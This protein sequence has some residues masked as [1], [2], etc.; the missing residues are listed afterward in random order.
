MKMG[1]RI[2]IDSATL[3]NKGLEIIEAHWL[4]GFSPAQIDVLIHPES[5]IH[6][7]VEFN[8][9]AIIAQLAVPDMRLPIQYVLTYPNRVTMNG[10][11]LALD[12]ASLRRLTFC[13]PDL[14]R[15]P[16]LELARKA[17]QKGGTAPC[18]LNA[19]DEVAVEAFLEKRLRFMDIPWVIEKV[20]D[21]T[22]KA[23]LGSLQSVL[24][25]DQEARRL[26]SEFVRRATPGGE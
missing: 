25:C 6:S 21:A 15:F 10:N 1:G 20:V 18:A 19:A 11:A 24:E 17:L 7:M 9:G 8:D 26:A 4:F 22:G 12:L 13:K 16:C 14:R 23:Q 2:T 3:M 5:V